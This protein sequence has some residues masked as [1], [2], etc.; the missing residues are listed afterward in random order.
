MAY[1]EYYQ[2]T[3]RWVY[4]PDHINYFTFDSLSR[5]LAARD[6][7]KSTDRNF[8]LS[9][10]AAGLNY[11]ADEEARKVG[12]LVTGFENS[13]KKTGRATLLKKYYE[14]LARLGLAVQYSCML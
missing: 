5:L 2:E 13:F 11:Y 14:T 9:F 7:G 12:P 6:S 10:S 1:A 3:Y 8:P 4:L